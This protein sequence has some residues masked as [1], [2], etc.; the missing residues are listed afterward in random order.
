MGT[1][2]VIEEALPG[3]DRPDAS[4]APTHRL[5]AGTELV[6]VERLGGWVR[7]AT[8]D[9]RTVWVDG[10]RLGLPA[11]EVPVDAPAAAR[12]GGALTAVVVGLGLLL[13]VV[14]IGLLVTGDDEVVSVPTTET[15]GT[16]PVTVPATVPPAATEPPSDTTADAG[17]LVIVEDFEGAVDWPVG[18]EG[19]LT[20]TVTGGAYRIDH[21]PD[22]RGVGYTWLDFTPPPTATRLALYTT[23]GQRSP[24]G[25]GCGLALGTGDPADPRVTV[26]FNDNEGGRASAFLEPSWGAEFSAFL[27]WT[28]APPGTADGSLLLNTVVEDGQL[29]VRVG[30][31]LTV[32]GTLAVGPIVPA[33]IGLVVVTPSDGAP[34]SCTFD[35]V[36]LVLE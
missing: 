29:E 14:G 34:S 19:T 18:T 21:D 6:E 3:R 4:E 2:L 27:D 25:V 17:S 23:I 1:R 24:F 30:D 7:V 9:G 5:E 31:E 32:M 12:S 8:V 15:P 11:A 10:R 36:V 33:E 26:L 13:V 20:R 22:G 35:D 28:P 16:T